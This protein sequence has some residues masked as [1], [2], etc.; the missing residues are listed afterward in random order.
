LKVAHDKDHEV[1]RYKTL[2][3]GESRAR[4][5]MADAAEDIARHEME[6]G[7]WARTAKDLFAGAAGGVA[8]VLLGKSMLVLF[9]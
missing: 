9:G 1:S 5:K 4:I 8:Q 2:I 7:S 3:A 6:Q